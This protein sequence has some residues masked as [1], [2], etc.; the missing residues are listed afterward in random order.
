MIDLRTPGEV[1]EHGAARVSA[2]VHHLPLAEVLPATGGHG[3]HAEAAMVAVS[4]YDTL[5]A[6][7]EVVRETLAVLT[8]PS[9]YPAVVCCSSGIDRTGVVTA[10][11]LGLLGVPD[12][13]V[14]GDYSASREATLRRIGRLRF[15]HPA[16][17]GPA[18]DRFG[19]GL[20]GVVPEAMA[21]C[22]ERVRA[23][24]GSLAGYAESID[25]SGAVP[26]L[27]ATMLALDARR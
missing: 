14:V 11:I 4:Y 17:A 2:G 27:R 26:Y 5:V 23:E 1:A 22:L 3:C 25:M 24:F 8:D 6:G 15:E 9:T 20:L 12:D 16:A 10:V 7:Y 18:L 13:I 19:P 21:R